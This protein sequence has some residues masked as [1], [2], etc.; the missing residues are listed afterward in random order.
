MIKH[1]SIFTTDGRF[2]ARQDL[3]DVDYLFELWNQGYIVIFR[4]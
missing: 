3:S 1:I 4:V 2:I